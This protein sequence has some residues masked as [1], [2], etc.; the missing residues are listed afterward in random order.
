M[1][2]CI[3]Q[4]TSLFLSAQILVL[5][6]QIY[7]TVHKYISQCTNIFLSAQ[8]YFSEHKYISHC[9]YKLSVHKYICSAQIYLQCANIFAV[10]K[11][12]CSAQIH[13]QVHKYIS[14]CT[15]TVLRGESG[16]QCCPDRGLVTLVSRQFQ[17]RP[18][19]VD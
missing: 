15:N 5:S 6:A 2:K 16:N 18:S 9:I 7:F 14:Q 4:F 11:Y 3:S 19:L 1:H 13:F 17:K 8:I 12:I 10:R